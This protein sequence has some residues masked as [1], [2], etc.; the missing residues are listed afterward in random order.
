MSSE[1]RATA[2]VSR[3]RSGA[4][5]PRLRDRA[6]LAG[7][8]A[9][10]ATLDRVAP[11]VAA[12]WAVRLWCTMPASGG[13]RRDERTSLGETC[14]LQLPGGRSVVTEVWGEGE[15]VY[16]LHGWGGWRGQLG[17]FVAPLVAAGRRVVALDA[18]SHGESPPGE[19]GPRRSTVIE[20]AD[21]L[22]AAT[23]RYGQ[24]SGVL[25][26]SLGCTAAALAAADGMPAGRLVLVAPNAAVLTMTDVMAHRLGY[27][28]R[29]KTRFD[30]RLANLAGRPLADFDL[31]RMHSQPRTLVVH[32][33]A[34]KEVP[35]ADGARVAEAWRSAELMTTDGLGHQ[36]IL[37]DAGVI[38]RV[39]EFLS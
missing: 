32:D 24:A 9:A 29:T 18:P 11:E 39:A 4:T 15:P 25:A 7:I 36:R 19:L 28:D 38:D 2:A 21:A 17:A 37:R 8:R 22:H 34:D 30:A 16:L 14:R 23:A 3:G 10:F 1:S 6:R 20:F 33:R 27:T 5:A 12:R 31:A 13:R 35:Y 26:H